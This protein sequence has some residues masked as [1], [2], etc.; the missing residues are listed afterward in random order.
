MLARNSPRKER[1]A[2]KFAESN[3]QCRIGGE[4]VLLSARRK[5]VGLDLDQIRVFI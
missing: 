4:D 2:R 3:D 1:T 5:I